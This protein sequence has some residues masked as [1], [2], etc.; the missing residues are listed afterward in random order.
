[1]LIVLGAITL[2]ACGGGGS[3]ANRESDP[4]VVAHAPEMTIT[5][6]EARAP[7]SVGNIPAQTLTA[8]G[9]PGEVEIALY[10]QDPAD[11]PLTYSAESS[12]PGIISV[13]IS[14]TTLTLTPVSAGD[15]TVTV[16]ASDGSPETTQ[17]FAATVQEPVLS[18]ST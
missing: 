9:N 4:D 16:T 14:G 3:P 18:S 17:T 10:F 1:M 8:G 13:A 15:A 7:Q 2:S 6:P 12:D 11:D 5:P